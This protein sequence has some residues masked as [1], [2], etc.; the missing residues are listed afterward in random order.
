MVSSPHTNTTT[1]SNGWLWWNWV[2]AENIQWHFVAR[3]GTL[4][5]SVEWLV[6]RKIRG[7]ATSQPWL[8]DWAPLWHATHRL[9]STRTW[10]RTRFIAHLTEGKAAFC[11]LLPL[12]CLEKRN[13]P[14]LRRIR[15]H[16]PRLCCD[17]WSGI[18]STK[19][20]EGRQGFHQRWKVGRTTHLLVR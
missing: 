19:K 18:P 12:G 2:N 6:Q 20:E 10:L 17:R 15:A 8:F 4:E 9:T 1:S 16:C 7:D 13:W 11:C 3:S 14:F 5:L